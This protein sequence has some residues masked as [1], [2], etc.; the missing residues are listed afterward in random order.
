MKRLTK[1]KAQ[2]LGIDLV[3]LRK[4]LKDGFW[5]K[6]SYQGIF[7]LDSEPKFYEPK[8]FK[9]FYV[10]WYEKSL[11]KFIPTWTIY[12]EKGEVMCDIA[13]LSDYGKTWALTKE[14]LE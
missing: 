8:G 1:K 6:E 13:K 9:L 10:N 3:T 5:M 11:G 12:R 4:A 7:D 14:E 2:E